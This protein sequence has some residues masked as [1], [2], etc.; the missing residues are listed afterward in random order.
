MFL[1]EYV[2]RFILFV[3]SAPVKS[4]PIDYP[5]ADSPQIYAKNVDLFL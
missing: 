5:L 3:I 1:G 2:F 4:I